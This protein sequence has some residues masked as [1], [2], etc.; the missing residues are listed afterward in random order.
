[1]TLRRLAF[2]QWF[3]FLAGGTVWFASFLAGVGTSQ[4]VCNPG[5]GRWGVPHDGVQLALLIAAVVLVGSAQA[6]SIV[7]FRATREAKEQDPPPEG[8]LH[9]FA[10]GAML[11]NTIFL[12]IIVLSEVAAIVDRACHQA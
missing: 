4:A 11:G 5:S 12:M 6:A 7:V 1:M 8:R 10:T 3:G 9:F 2:L